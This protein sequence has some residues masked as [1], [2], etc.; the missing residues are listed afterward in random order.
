MRISLRQPRHKGELRCLPDETT[1]SK[2]AMS[3]FLSRGEAEADVEVDIEFFTMIVDA[4]DDSC[5]RT[6]L[7][8]NV[9]STE[10]SPRHASEHV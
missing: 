5:C 3:N 4:A 6:D 2:P 8:G 10:D 7:F 9:D 1:A